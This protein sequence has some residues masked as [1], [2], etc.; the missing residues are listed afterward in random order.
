MPSAGRALHNQTLLALRRRGIEVV[1][2]THAAG[3]SSTGD[4]ATDAR[5]PL[6]ERFEVTEATVHAVARTKA[7]GGRVVAVGT[8]VVRALESAARLSHGGPLRAATGITDLIL[9]ADAELHVADALLTGV[10][11]SDTTHFMLLGAFASRP[12]LDAALK[13]AEREGFL[14][15][16]LG[17]TW[18]VWRE[19][20]SAPRATVAA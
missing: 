14:G 1:S 4:P 15:H 8:S 19:S 9:R 18:L 7:R 13:A 2:V 5:L 12:V 11:E 16:E 10:H 3:L 20:A 6:P 17:D